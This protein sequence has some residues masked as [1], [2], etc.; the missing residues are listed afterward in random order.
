[1][2]TSCTI[3]QLQL[4]SHVKLGMREDSYK[5]GQLMFRL[6][7]RTSTGTCMPRSKGKDCRRN[8]RVHIHADSAK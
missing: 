4:K 2:G 5:Y 1:M 6:G 7:T 3:Y 8:A